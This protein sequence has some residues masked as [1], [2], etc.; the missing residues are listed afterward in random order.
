EEDF[1][2]IPRAN[3]IDP[4][5]PAPSVEL[6]L[7]AF[8]TAKFIDHMH[9]TAV[10]SLTDQPNG[11]DLCR[12]VYGD[13]L[14]IVPYVRPGFGLARTAADVFDA[15]PTVEGLILLK[16]G[17]FTFGADAREAYERMIEMVTRAEQRLARGRKIF[18]MAKPP[19]NVAK[20][21]DVAP[22]LRGACSLPDDRIEGAWTR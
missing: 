1:V 21:A 5:A 11:A 15:R 14:G 18:A 8:M 10:L 22:I 7:H 4:A 13:R 19:G 16:H 9:A 2:R 20:V 17:I 12:E 6:L 3:L